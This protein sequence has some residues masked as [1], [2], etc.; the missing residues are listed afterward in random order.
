MSK[1]KIKNLEFENLEIPSSGRKEEKQ[2]KA[3]ELSGNIIET[4][5]GKMKEHN[6]E[7]PKN[8][9]SLSQLKKVFKSG[10][11]KTP[12]ETEVNNPSYWAIAWVNMFLRMVKGDKMERVTKYISDSHTIDISETWSPSEEDFD[13]AKKD[14]DKN[15]LNYIFG[16]IDELYL[17]D[18]KK[19]NHNWV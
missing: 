6:K 17:D 3:I 16:N 7:N 14:V 11:S 15:K 9:V 1:F 5:H 8:K 2:S 10:A 18:Y 19:T 12:L 4:L 13:Q